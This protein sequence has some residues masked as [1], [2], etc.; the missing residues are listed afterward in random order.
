MIDFE[1]NFLSLKIALIYQSIPLL[2]YS[3]LIPCF[4]TD[5]SDEARNCAAAAE[6]ILHKQLLQHPNQPTPADLQ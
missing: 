4:D 5:C 1:M 3:T 2:N 6:N